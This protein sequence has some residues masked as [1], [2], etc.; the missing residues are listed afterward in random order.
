MDLKKI[1]KFINI[2]NNKYLFLIILV[3][4]VFMLFS[5][6]GG[7]KE[8]N[9]ET[10]NITTDIYTNDEKRLKDILSEI[11]GVD[12]VDVMIT[13]SSSPKSDIAYEI[14]Q[15]KSQKEDGETSK[16]SDESYDKQAIMS[17]GEPF[18]TQYTYPEVRGVVVVAEGVGQAA[19][20]Q[21]VIDAVT[22]AMGIA[23]HKVYVAEK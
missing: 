2:E 19:V 13:Y 23:P 12:S 10:N 14:N 15:S 17:S 22:C 6:G 21:R 1:T 9:K 18:V 3:G 4:V 8:K 20:R 5:G 11:N 7:D 16:S